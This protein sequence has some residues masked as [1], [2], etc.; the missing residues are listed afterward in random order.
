MYYRMDEIHSVTMGPLTMQQ[1]EDYEDLINTCE[2]LAKL[3]ED[4]CR[5]L[6]C[7]EIPWSPTYKRVMLTLLYWQIRGK[8]KEQTHTNM[9]QL[10]VFQDK[11][12]ITYDN[13]L[14]MVDIVN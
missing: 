10:I 7:G 11:L 1:A 6:H 13:T 5:Q 14:T 8:H 4:K 2:E 3:S 9:R 12:K